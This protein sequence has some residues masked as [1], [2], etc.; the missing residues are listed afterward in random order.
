MERG[1]ERAFL[2]PLPVAGHLPLEPD[3]VERLRRFGLRSL[4]QLAALPLAAVEAQFGKEGLVAL[5]LARGEDSRPLLPWQPPQRMEESSSLDPPVDNLEPLL[6]LARGMA[7]RLGARLLQGAAAATSVRLRLDLEAARG[8]Q[9]HVEAL[10]RLRAPASG[11]A[12][13]WPPVAGLLKRQQ[14]SAPGGRITLRLSGFC[15]SRSRQLD[16]LT[17]RDG[18]LED[19]VRRWPCSPTPPGLRCRWPSWP[20]RRA[21]W[22]RAASAGCRLTWP[23]P[24][25]DQAA[26]RARRRAG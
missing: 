6:F 10:L 16:L 7:D 24:G 2:E 25:D 17:R 19:V 11:A 22:R 20:K 26:G 18:R 5:R 23:W 15:P 9:N 21:C 14:L 1:R 8:E 3:L 12:D 4:G 13:L